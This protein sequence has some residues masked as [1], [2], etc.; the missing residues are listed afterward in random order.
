MKHGMSGRRRGN[1]ARASL[2]PT[3]PRYVATIASKVRGYL[4]SRSGF[5][6][7]GFLNRRDFSMQQER[8]ILFLDYAN[9]HHAARERGIQ[10][11]YQHL[12]YYVG[13]NRFLVDPHC[14]VPIDPRNPHRLDRDIEELW[15]AGYIV[16]TRTG[17]VAG[18]TYKCNFD[19]E[20]AMDMLKAVNQVKPDII[21]LASGDA[22]FVPL[23]QEVRKSG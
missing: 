7:P 17:S 19:V 22:D 15:N 18:S 14:Y 21:V 6:R 9:I 2:A 16:T 23:I 13:E 1:R 12:L 3:M 8:V 4:R 11:N 5:L 20:I 10:L